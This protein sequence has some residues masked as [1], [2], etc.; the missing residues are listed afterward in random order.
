[1]PTQFKVFK[2]SGCWW[3]RV[4]K[5]LAASACPRLLGRY[6]VQLPRPTA[7]LPRQKPCCLA[8]QSGSQQQPYGY[9]MCLLDSGR[10]NCQ[11]QNP[12]VAQPGVLVRSWLAA[13]SCNAAAESGA[14]AAAASAASLTAL[15]PALPLPVFPQDLLLHDLKQVCTPACVCWVWCVALALCWVYLYVAQPCITRRGP[16]RGTQHTA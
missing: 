11:D 1:M 10:A 15:T 9:D 13:A 4:S 16:C 3:F 2:T 6:L 5:R 7:V 8:R 12:P 14:A